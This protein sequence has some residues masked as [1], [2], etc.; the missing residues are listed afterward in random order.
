MSC[1][2][3]QAPAPR[4]LD[5]GFP[6]SHGVSTCVV[7][8]TCSNGHDS[9]A[10]IRNSKRQILQRN[11]CLQKINCNGAWHIYNLYKPIQHNGSTCS[12]CLKKIKHSY[13]RSAFAIFI[14]PALHH[15]PSVVKKGS[16]IWSNRI[17][18]LK[19]EVIGK[20]PACVRQYSEEWV[21]LRRGEWTHFMNVSKR[22]FLQVTRCERHQQDKFPLSFTR[23]AGCH[24]L[25]RKSH[26]RSDSWSVTVVVSKDPRIQY[27]CFDC[28]QT[29]ATWS[30]YGFPKH[31]A[32][33][34]RLSAL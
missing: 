25:L 20:L 19:A 2:L 21:S 30:N 4:G 13:W 27:T 17:F 15:D 11:A 28:L 8:T 33:D 18:Q 24:R 5:F 26:A 7:P 29:W 12:T 6:Q 14:G 16:I 23:P 9:W 3:Q 31:L 32:C 10:S 34:L 1:L 22:H